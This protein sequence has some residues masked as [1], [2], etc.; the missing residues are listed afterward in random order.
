MIS[1]VKNMK[2]RVSIWLY[3]F[4]T[5]LTSFIYERIETTDKTYE[6]VKKRFREAWYH[7]LL[8]DYDL[9]LNTR[10]TDP[11]K[12]GLVVELPPCV[13]KSLDQYYSKELAHG[14]TFNDHCRCLFRVMDR[15]EE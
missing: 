2:K 12:Y 7:D 13:M 3:V 4:Q 15:E 6:D 9:F 5:T 1:L 14:S 10:C 11:D 8:K